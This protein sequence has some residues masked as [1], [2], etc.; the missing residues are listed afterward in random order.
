MFHT[1]HDS[2]SFYCPPAVFSLNACI[3]SV[4]DDQNDL[5][6]KQKKKQSR[7]SSWIWTGKKKE[8]KMQRFNFIVFL[9]IEELKQH[10]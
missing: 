9:E 2:P 4:K 8:K 1:A 5:N 10:F 7:G 3:S 6:V